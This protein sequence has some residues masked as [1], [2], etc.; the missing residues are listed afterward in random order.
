MYMVLSRVV[1]FVCLFVCVC[2]CVCVCVFVCHRLH[3][4]FGI[5]MA[6][7]IR[8]DIYWDMALCSVVGEYQTAWC[9]IPEDCS[10]IA[11]CMY[12]RK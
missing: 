3:I 11:T 12:F 5:L 9:R 10:I 8:N 7:S 2:V 6:V 1:C 4:R